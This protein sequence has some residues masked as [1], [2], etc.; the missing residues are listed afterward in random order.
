MGTGCTFGVILA[1]T[2]DTE[3][4]QQEWLPHRTFD[5]EQEMGIDHK[6]LIALKSMD[7]GTIRM[8]LFVERYRV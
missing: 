2:E 4:E 8:N 3:M 7:T 5:Q 1:T 6:E